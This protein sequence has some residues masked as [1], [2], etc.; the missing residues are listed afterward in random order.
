MPM[1]IVA[2]ESHVVSLPFD[3]GGPHTSFAGVPWTHLDILLVRVETSDGFVGWGEAFGHVAIPATKAALDGIVAPMVLG[4]DAQDIAQLSDDTLK[5]VHLLGRN[6]PFVFAYSGIEIALWDI[7]GQRAGLPLHRLLGSTGSH[8]TIAA[9]ASLLRY[10]DLPLVK[11][12]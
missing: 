2:V 11:K 4:R 1:K 7:A 10:T 6:G 9:Y 3:M 8:D 5:A 12:M